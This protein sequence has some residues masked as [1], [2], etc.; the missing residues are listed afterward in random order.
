MSASDVWRRLLIDEDLPRSLAADL[1]SAGF[2]AEHVEDAGLRGRPDQV[3][4]HHALDSNRAMVTR[5]VGMI[6]PSDPSTALVPGFVLVRIPSAV[7][8]A[9][10]KLMVVRAVLTLIQSVPSG[11]VVVVEPGRIRVRGQRRD[12]R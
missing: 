6:A 8:S 4:R 3:L 10:L 11:R 5:D 12:R 2:D 1:R 7:P 9:D